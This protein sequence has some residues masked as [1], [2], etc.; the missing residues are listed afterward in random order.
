MSDLSSPLDDHIVRVLHLDDEEN[1]LKFA[2]HF[3]ERANPALS[4]KCT[5]SHLEALEWLKGDSFDCV[6]SDY[7][8]PEINGIDFARRVRETSEIP[9]ILYTGHGSEEVAEEAFSI[10]IDDYFRKEP[11]PSHYQVLAKRITTVVERHKAV[12]E[13]HRNQEL[14]SSFMDEVSVSIHIYDSDLHLIGVNLNAR[15]T[16]LITDKDIGKHILEM[17]PRLEETERYRR[18]LDVLESGKPLTVEAAFDE[19]TF[20]IRHTSIRAFR[21]LDG[22]ALMFTDISESKRVEEELRK[23][24]ERYRTIVENSPNAISVSVDDVIVYVNQKRMELTG[25][26][27][28]SRLLGTGGIEKVVPED[29][30]RVSK[31]LSARNKG[32]SIAPFVEFR[33]RKL[34]GSVIH[35]V[36]HVSFI[37]WQG[38]EAVMHILLD[39]T[40]RKDAEE[41]LRSLHRHS[42][43]LEKAETMDDVYRITYEVMEKALGYE[44]NDVISVEDDHLVDVYASG[45]TLIPLKLPLSGPGITVRAATTNQSQLVPDVREDPDFVQGRSE[46]LSELAVP[47]SVAGEVVAVL[48]VERT[49][50]H[51]LTTKDQELL[52]TLALNVSSA[53][54]RMQQRE[55]IHDSE[56][57]YRKLLDSSPDSIRVISTLTRA[58]LFCNRI[59]LEHLGYDSYEELL[60]KNALELVAPEDRE[61]VSRYREARL[62][63]EN[64]PTKYELKLLRKDG[65]MIEVE[66]N[67]STIEFEGQQAALV[68]SRDISERKRMETELREREGK[69]RKLFEHSNDAIFIHKFDGTILDINERACEMTGYTREELLSITVPALHPPESLSDS[70]KAYKA[71]LG[72]GS[73]RFETKFRKANGSIINVEISSRIIDQ[74]EGLI[75]G[76]V[77]DITSRKEFEE[78]LRET[79]WRHG[80]RIKELT[81]LYEAL[82]AM[83]ETESIEELGPK[84]VHI[85][86]HAVHYPEI[87]VPFLEVG[88]ETYTG[89]GYSE[90]LTHGIYSVIQS[91]GEPSGRLSVFYTEDRPFMLP[92]EQ[93]MVDGLAQSLGAWYEGTLASNTLNEYASKLEEL[94]DE[95]TRELI[96]AE[97]MVAAGKVAAMVA[98]DLRTPLQ[99]INNALFLLQEMPER[100][101]EMIQ[102][103][104]DSV[105]RADELMEAFRDQIRD[106]PLQL[107]PVDLGGL[108]RRSVEAA[109]AHSKVVVSLDLGEGMGEVMLDDSRMRRVMDNLISNALEA[110]PEGGELRVSADA[111]GDSLKVSVSDTGV[112][113]PEDQIP[114]LYTPFH[115]TKKRGLGLGL[116]YCKRTVEAHGGE[117]MVDSAVGRG[118]TFTILMN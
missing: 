104:R 14:L 90:A 75:Q 56:R 70:E 47:V 93:K 5:S 95:K 59:S 111:E 19:D 30:E 28:R 36:D 39:I 105:K 62:R 1:Q 51:A 91:K 107:K 7:K 3:L 69:Y 92:E 61:R 8:M 72:E 25:H 79:I 21:V 16:G 60:E 87:T 2:K 106:S 27:D 31:R 35:V 84:I 22:L 109:Q 63:G 114:D 116:A 74:E 115:S 44:A 12:S 13:L 67:I 76:I 6:V 23:S 49:Q 18:Y 41:K 4:V 78:N 94:V 96:G 103:I 65:S 38:E 29:Q 20:N 15:E 9:F 54:N 101:E 85:L 77:R 68:L 64:A 37:E 73:T 48:N 117:I 33:M 110:M 98:H 17:N 99:T 50:P 86:K 24:E 66:C 71:T 11:D 32:E 108:V 43:M 102:T 58:H 113:I 46:S 26:T 112:G 118:T 34:D 80:E 81:C 42:F 100:T 83:Q 52:E 55:V 45:V 82:N 57:K 40:E 89:E 97:Q 10:G 88:D 53:V